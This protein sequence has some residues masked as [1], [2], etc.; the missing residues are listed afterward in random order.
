MHPDCQRR[1]VGAALL[2]HC[3]A[4]SDAAGVPMLLESSE[5]GRALYASRGFTMVRMSRM[6]YGGA[7]ASWPVMVREPVGKAEAAEPGSELGLS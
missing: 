7:V 2:A 4:L 6:E 5:A 3:T 1:G